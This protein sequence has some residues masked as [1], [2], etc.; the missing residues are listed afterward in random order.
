MGNIFA[1]VFI[2]AAHIVIIIPIHCLYIA[3]DSLFFLFFLIDIIAVFV[4]SNVLSVCFVVKIRGK[5]RETAVT[6]DGQFYL[7]DPVH[8]LSMGD[9]ASGLW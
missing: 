2:K 8:M 4:I 5:F 1:I 9:I 3:Y 7:L 6:S